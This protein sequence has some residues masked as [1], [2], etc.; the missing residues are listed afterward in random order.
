MAPMSLSLYSGPFKPRATY[1]S[2]LISTL[3]SQWLQ[4]PLGHSQQCHSISDPQQPDSYL[5]HLSPP[6]HPHG[7]HASL[8]PMHMK[9][10][11][12]TSHT[13][14]L[15][16][17][18]CPSPH[19]PKSWFPSTLVR[20][21]TPLRVLAAS[22][23]ENKLGAQPSRSLA[24]WRCLSCSSCLT[25]AKR[26]SRRT[27]Q[28]GPGTLAFAMSNPGIPSPFSSRTSDSASQAHASGHPLC[29]AFLTPKPPSHIPAPPSLSPG[30]T[31]HA[32]HM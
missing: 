17:G 20:L 21:L 18:H 9:A 23:V 12:I 13:V 11:S 29:E 24:S 14:S 2:C 1:T 3:P 8:A 30:R 4:G 16:P 10:V 28:S 32:S 31:A 25:M 5:C 19:H 6:L 22:R 15:A 7:S 27:S 26:R